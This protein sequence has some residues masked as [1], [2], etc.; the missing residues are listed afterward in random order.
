MTLSATMLKG[1]PITAEKNAFIEELFDQMVN[2]LDK[3]TPL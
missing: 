1:N 2:N 3:W